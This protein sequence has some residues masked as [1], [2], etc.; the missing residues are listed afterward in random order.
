[1][2]RRSSEVCRTSG[3]TPASVSSAPPRIASVVPFSDSGTSTHPVNWFS[4]FQVL[5]P[6][7][8]RIKVY[9]MDG[10]SRRPV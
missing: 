4:A 9:V 8:N 10:F 5:S 7:R 6:C 1:M 2:A 3:A